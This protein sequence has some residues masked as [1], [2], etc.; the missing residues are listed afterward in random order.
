MCALHLISHTKNFTKYTTDLRHPIS[1]LY[2]KMNY[3]PDDLRLL[4]AEDRGAIC[5]F[6]QQPVTSYLSLLGPQGCEVGH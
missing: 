4:S 6:V 5:N 3:I 1:S 2:S